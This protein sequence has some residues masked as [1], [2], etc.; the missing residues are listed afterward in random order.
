MNVDVF[1]I[2]KGGF[3]ASYVS[4]PKGNLLLLL[5]KSGDFT[6]WCCVHKKG[7][8]FPRRKKV[9]GSLHPAFFPDFWTPSK[10]K[11]NPYHHPKCLGRIVVLWTVNIHK[12][13]GIAVAQKSWPITTFFC[14]HNDPWASIA[15]TLQTSD[16]KLTNDFFFTSNMFRKKVTGRAL[17][18]SMFVVVRVID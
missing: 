12:G 18:G 6:H 2:G 7:R 17:L 8:F 11:T 4:L 16:V 13:F 1:P 14:L 9:R 15:N 3:P 10:K 5:Q